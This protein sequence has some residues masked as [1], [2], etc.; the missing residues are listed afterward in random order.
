MYCDPS[1]L[2]ACSVNMLV[3]SFATT[4]SAKQKLPLTT[5]PSSGIDAMEQGRDREKWTQPAALSLLR[6]LRF[7]ERFLKFLWKFSS[8]FMKG[9]VRQK[10]TFYLFGYW[11]LLTAG[12][13]C[14]L[15]VKVPRLTCLRHC[16]WSA[17]VFCHTAE[18]YYY[19]ARGHEREIAVEMLISTDWK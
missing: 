19:F 17:P 16:R 10:S 2:F 6:F 12:I 15:N 5:R 14:Y 4:Y 18:N 8:G 3:R 13:S 11:G 9:Y 7:Y 1:C